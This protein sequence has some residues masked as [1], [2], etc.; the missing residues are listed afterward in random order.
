MIHK[1]YKILNSCL[2][3]FLKLCFVSTVC[4]LK[5][6]ILLLFTFSIDNKIKEI[7]LKKVTSFDYIINN[8]LC[9]LQVSVLS[10]FV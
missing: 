6:D 2:N 10:L 7:L 8:H 9:M 4:E 5:I 1:R 3:E